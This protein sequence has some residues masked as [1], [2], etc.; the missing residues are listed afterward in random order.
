MTAAGLGLVLLV[1]RRS[2][3]LLLPRALVAG[4]ATVLGCTCSPLGWSVLASAMT[5]RDASTA[6]IDEWAPLWRAPAIG[7]ATWSAAAL[8]LVLTLLAWRRR[9]QDPLLAVWS[10]ATGV[11]VVLGVSAARF[12]PMAAVLALPAAALWISGTD[13]QAARWR[14]T[15]ALLASG[16]A[17]AAGVVLLVLAITRLPH[18][19]EPSNG[20]ASRDTVEAI[21]A[22]SR[23]LNEYDDGGWI[24]YL[25]V[26]DGVLVAQDGRNDAYGVVVLDRVQQLIDGRAGAL[27]YLRDH[28][29]SCLLLS[30]DRPIVAQAEAAGWQVAASD[31]DRVLVLAPVG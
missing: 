3:R 22:G 18:L 14:R 31:E 5:T 20:I 19:G 30:P 1:H 11:L 26:D 29:V 16:V 21:P 28:G 7:W 24:T 9:P 2:W 23:V 4:A 13:W 12:S 6:M 8:G 17:T 10:G 15:A 27:G 25:R